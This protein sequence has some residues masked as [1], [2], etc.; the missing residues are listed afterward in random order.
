MRGF[1]Q[2]SERLREEAAGYDELLYPQV[3]GGTSE[4]LREEAAGT[5]PTTYPTT[6][7]SPYV[8][9]VEPTSNALLWVLVGLGFLLLMRER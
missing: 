3:V 5:A 8:V 7:P 4:R 2:V 6:A 9:T 1:G